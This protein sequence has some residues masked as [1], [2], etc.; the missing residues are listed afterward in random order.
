MSVKFGTENMFQ[1]L[2]LSVP[3]GIEFVLVGIGTLEDQT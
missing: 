1:F 2:T 3:A